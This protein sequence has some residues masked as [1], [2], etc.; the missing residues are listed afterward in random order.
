MLVQLFLGGTV[1]R[2]WPASC[3]L[4]FL[5]CYALFHMLDSVP[6]ASFSLIGPHGLGRGRV[7]PFSLSGLESCFP[8]R[9]NYY[10]DFEIGFSNYLLY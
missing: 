6:L 5:I 10:T 9:D 3:H 8:G 4:A 2:T 1:D 7:T